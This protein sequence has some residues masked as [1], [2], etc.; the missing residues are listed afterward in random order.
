MRS[1]DPG[2]LPQPADR[3]ALGVVMNR[4]DGRSPIPATGHEET[5]ANGGHRNPVGQPAC[6]GKELHGTCGIALPA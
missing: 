1:E 2:S 6:G 4:L 3:V 5:F